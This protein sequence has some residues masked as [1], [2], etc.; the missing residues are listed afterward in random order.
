MT[1]E[2]KYSKDRILVGL[3][4]SLKKKNGQKLVKIKVG[5]KK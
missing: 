3:E 2:Q 1:Y 4:T 5:H